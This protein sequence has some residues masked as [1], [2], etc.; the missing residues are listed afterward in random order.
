MNA[1]FWVIYLVLV[2]FLSGM[3]YIAISEDTDVPL[4]LSDDDMEK[5]QEKVHSQIAT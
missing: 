2:I 1:K 5:L 3:A 4:A